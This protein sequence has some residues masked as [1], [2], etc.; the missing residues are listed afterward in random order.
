MDFNK[1]TQ[2]SQQALQDGQSIAVDH[3]HQE[4]DG[5]H[6]LLALCGQEDGLIPRLL[7]KLG[8]PADV[9]IAELERQ[10]DK[11]DDLRTTRSGD[12]VSRLDDLGGK[13]Q[14]SIQ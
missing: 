6:L 9:I 11:I 7:D 8:R 2:K 12:P 13:Q 4:V 5:E 3:G 10:L 14:E 1:L